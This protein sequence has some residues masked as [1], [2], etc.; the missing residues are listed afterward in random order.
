MKVRDIMTGTIKTVGY[1]TTV[2]EA[3]VKMKSFDIGS[4]PVIQNGRIVGMITDR[5]I[6]VRV[7]AAK[8]D[9]QT[10]RVGTVMS[11]H[12]VSCSDD[13]DIEEAARIMG[14]HQVHRLLVIDDNSR[15]AGI[16]SIGDIARKVDDE[17]LLHEVLAQ[18]CE[19]EIMP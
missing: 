16:L 14:E 12:S 7:V 5:D 8:M 15:I 10:T 3:A 17:H 13:T 11:S 2:H 6:V 4:L 1:D 9:P 18:V 19:P